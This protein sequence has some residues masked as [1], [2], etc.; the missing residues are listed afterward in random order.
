M[1]ILSLDG[2]LLQMMRR[3]EFIASLS[4]VEILHLLFYWINKSKP[5]D[6]DFAEETLLS[7]MLSSKGLLAL[8]E[9]MVSGKPINI[10]GSETASPRSLRLWKEAREVLEGNEMIKSGKMKLR[11]LEV[12]ATSE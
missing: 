9:L 2:T 4:R 7:T 5:R 12:G 10:L 1:K 6:Q 11:T 8:K 3:E